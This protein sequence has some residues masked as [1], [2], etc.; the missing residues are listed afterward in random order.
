MKNFVE[1]GYVIV[2][3]AISSELISRVHNE[4]KFVLNDYKLSNVD[5]Q[6]YFDDYFK[7]NTNYYDE[8]KPIFEHLLYKNILD[9]IVNSKKLNQEFVNI[10][11]KDLAFCCFINASFSWTYCLLHTSDTSSRME[12]FHT[13]MS[14]SL[15]LQDLP[16]FSA[17]SN[18]SAV[19]IQI[20]IPAIYKS[21]IVFIIIL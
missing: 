10:L 13:I 1:N 6:N 16:T 3:N 5:T 18:L 8:L 9:D 19:S 20:F 7:L 17:V 21:L 14:F 12:I 15:N 2:K 4:I 11:G